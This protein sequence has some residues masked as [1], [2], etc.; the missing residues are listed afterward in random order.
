MGCRDPGTEDEGGTVK[1]AQQDEGER[2]HDCPL[3]VG[4]REGRELAARLGQQRSAF[5]R[6]VL[7]LSPSPSSRS[8]FFARNQLQ[9]ADIRSFVNTS[10][11]G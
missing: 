7:Y 11:A 4:E 6:Y 5:A 2:H 1:T 9:R 8:L 3:K 10:V